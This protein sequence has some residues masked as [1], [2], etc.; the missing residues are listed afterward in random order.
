MTTG[1]STTP[2]SRHSQRAAE[3][4]DVLVVGSGAAGLAAAVSAA[5][6]GLRVLLL[7]R[8]E[9]LGG[10]SAIS[11]GWLYLPGNER[12][13]KRVGD[14]RSDVTS[15]LRQLAGAE[16]QSDRVEAFLD[17]VP[18]MVDFFERDTA[19]R[20]AY[21]DN[22][23]DYHLELAGA[24][25][26][27]RAICAEPFDARELGDKR[28]LLRPPMTSMS[29]FGVVPQIG[30]DLQQFIEANQSIRSF[31]YVAHRVLRNWGQ[32]VRY[33]RGTELANGS[34]LVAGLIKSADDLG[35]EFRTAARVEGLISQDGVVTGARVST[36]DGLITF[37]ADRG[38]VLAC[39]GFSH[40]QALRTA[41]FPHSRAGQDHHSAT[42]A[43]S[44]G[45]AR[46]L[47]SEV[48][49]VF[50][51]EVTQPAAWAPVSVFRGPGGSTRLFPHLRGIGL[52]GLIAVN[53]KGQRFTNEAD[54]YHDFGQAMLKDSVGEPD[55]HA[56]L[57]ADAQTMHR[58]G[59]GY[60]KP[61]PVPRLRYRKNGY[62]Y[63]GRT[64]G[65][66]AKAAGIDPEGL[67]RA[68]TEFN[69][70]AREGK[71]PAFHRGESEYNTFRGDKHHRPNPSIGPVER[72]PFYA[73]RISIGDLGTFAGLATDESSRVLDEDGLP[74]EGLFAA[75]SAA[76]SVFGGAYPGY[77][78]MLGPGMTF[79]YKIG[80]DL[81]AGRW[82]KEEA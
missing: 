75:G 22:A 55:V 51:T 79:G 53:R 69:R 15:Y 28:L 41:V 23:P 31:A 11:G 3:E 38:V 16:Y 56:F 12:G 33:R 63:V 40:D 44:D 76:A 10:T 42:A 48:G 1:S 29:V 74:I 60:A 81:A 14:T 27:G 4:C 43:S 21:P 72:G 8:D 34:A 49:G 32:R 73:T 62:L 19:V 25:V 26:G 13:A 52:P 5:Q 20:F 6:G 2:S 59:I 7:E 68:V 24:R 18:E 9:V 30:P 17:A 58:Y 71:D 67:V 50:L 78:A 82:P 39:G 36:R 77:G 57:L 47:A 46:R 54:S 70:H 61:W 80:R 64:L 37:R 66:L 65:E 35:V 45:D